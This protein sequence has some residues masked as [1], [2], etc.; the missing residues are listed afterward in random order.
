MPIQARAEDIVLSGLTHRLW[1]WESS[2]ETPKAH[3]DRSQ[4]PLFL[5]LHGWL[6]QGRSFDGMAELLVGHGEVWGLDFR[7]HGQ[8]EWI[9]RGGYYHFIDYLRDV[10]QLLESPRCQG[11]EVVV[12]GHSMGGSVASLVAGA[13]PDAVSALVLM[14]GSGPPARQPADT[15]ARS[16]VW[17]RDLSRYGK[18][19]KFYASAEEL[20]SRVGVIY[21]EFDD[22]QVQR[23]IR[24][25]IVFEAGQGWRWRYDPLHRC[26]NPIPFMQELYIAFAKEYKGPVLQIH[27]TKSR[28]ARRGDAEVQARETA[29]SGPRQEHGIEG[30]GHMMHFSHPEPCCAAILAWAWAW[31]AA[32][33][34]LTST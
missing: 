13:V 22:E 3:P 16:R 29:F 8:S 4:E 20:Q 30:A 5:L 9:G 11:R 6:D 17:L 24:S 21:P 26:T 25:A 2:A 28:L 23:F 33:P 10:C 1:R 12:I 34:P 32:L 27:G 14:E 18:G 31:R 19:P 7:G 15:L